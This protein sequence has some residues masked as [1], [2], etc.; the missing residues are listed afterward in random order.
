[1]H[2][3]NKGRAV[4]IHKEPLQISEKKTHLVENEQKACLP[5]WHLEMHSKTVM[6]YHLLILHL[7]K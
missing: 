3:T 2:I 7:C 1:M 6:T 5:H 4:K